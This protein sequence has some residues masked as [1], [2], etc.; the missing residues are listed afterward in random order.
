MAFSASGEDGFFV[1]YCPILVALLAIVRHDRL[2]HLPSVLLRTAGAIGD[3]GHPPLP[4]TILVEQKARGPPHVDGCALLLRFIQELQMT[5]HFT[6]GLGNDRVPLQAPEVEDPTNQCHA[7]DP[8]QVAK[9]AELVANGKVPF[10]ANLSSSE[11]ERLR[12]T[13]AELRRHRLIK[14][15][16]QAIAKDI[17]DGTHNATGR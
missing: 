11:T 17:H 3:R 6:L 16:A 10:P 4:I 1:R 9:L 8:I 15:I 7:D 14:F 13:V 5:S 2:P 12:E